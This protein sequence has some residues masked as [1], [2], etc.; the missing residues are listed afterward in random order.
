M[1]VNHLIMRTQKQD[2]EESE[3]DLKTASFRGLGFLVTPSS[4]FTLENVQRVDLSSNQL[5]RL[6]GARVARELPCLEVLLLHGNLL[7][8]L[9]DVLALSVSPRLRELDVRD[10]PLRLS[11]HR[12]YLLEALLFQEPGVDEELLLLLS[13][14]VNV[15][16]FGENDAVPS[17]AMHYRSQLPRRR[18]FPMLLMLNGDWITDLE[19]RQVESEHGRPNEARITA[20]PL[21]RV[22]TRF[23]IDTESS[24]EVQYETNTANPLDEDEDDDH[25][26]LQRLFRPNA[27]AA[28]S[29][30]TDERVTGSSEGA[31]E[32]A[33]ESWNYPVSTFDDL[34]SE[35]RQYVRSKSKHA[36][37]TL[38]RDG[39]FFESSTFVDCV[40][41]CE[42]SRRLTIR[43]VDIL[44]GSQVSS[45]GSGSQLLSRSTASQSTPALPISEAAATLTDNLTAKFSQRQ[46]LK[47]FERIAALQQK[48]MVV[49]DCHIEAAV[50]DYFLD[51]HLA[52]KV[53]TNQLLSAQGS[54]TVTVE[55]SLEASMSRVKLR[56]AVDLANSLT[57]F[58]EQKRMLQALIDA[59]KKVIEEER[60]WEE[61][62]AHRQRLRLINA[63]QYSQSRSKRD[64]ARA[65]V[66]EMQESPWQ[67]R[68]WQAKT[69]QLEQKEK[70]AVAVAESGKKK[71]QRS[72]PAKPKA[73][74]SASGSSRSLAEELAAPMRA[75]DQFRCIE[76][77]EKAAQDPLRAVNSHDLLVRC[78]EIRQN[79]DKHV[80]A[81][82][83]H[84]D[85]FLDDEAEWE[86]M[87]QDP[88]NVVRRHLRRKLY[89][90][91]QQVQIGS[92]EYFYSPLFE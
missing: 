9:E 69:A 6:P 4:L 40:A 57:D 16:R 12:L 67:E 49:N 39:H 13:K 27:Q 18:G 60:V 72:L 76:T 19:T 53:K 30:S 86:Q 25:E 2:E 82:A 73:V 75:V 55:A 41:Q 23:Q 85:R 59:D 48:R 44:T 51:D 26:L 64:V 15:K 38:G 11:H 22:L 14:D 80:R 58:K 71:E 87:R 91:V 52:Q 62:K 89:Q 90:D 37:G 10:N 42:R 29:G 32:D 45:S 47:N 63:R 7:H 79:K 77:V 78:S 50:G 92:T 35:D 88:I 74:A 70:E 61:Q 43:A 54:R 56:N 46:A 28:S 66:T 68:N 33:F 17:R 84:R 34:N 83:Q 36:D 31:R 8:V 20:I 81:L 21:P 65:T 1:V 5:A 24:Q 3:L